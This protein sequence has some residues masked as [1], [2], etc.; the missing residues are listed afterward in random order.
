MLS[1][2]LPE[3]VLI[4]GRGSINKL[5]KVIVLEWIHFVRS[6]YLTEDYAMERPRGYTIH[7]GQHKCICESV[8]WI[9]IQLHLMAALSSGHG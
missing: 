7:R 1:K 4:D 3:F 9:I 2:L 8:F 6:E 5:R